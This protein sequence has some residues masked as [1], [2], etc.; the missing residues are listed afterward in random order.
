MPLHKIEWTDKQCGWAV[1]HLTEEETTLAGKAAPDAC[2]ADIISQLK[3]REW[4]AGRILIRKLVE[5][6]GLTYHGLTKDDFGKPFLEGH[7]HHI[8]LSHSHPYV[9][10]Q[11]D[12]TSAVGIDVEQPNEKLLRIGPRVFDPGE[13]KDAGQ[14]IIKNCVYWC[15]KEALFKIYGQKGISFTRN[16]KVQPFILASHG[17]LDGRIILPGY[18]QFVKLAYAIE[19]DIVMVHTKTG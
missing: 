17:E 3:R 8:S 13:V 5:E 19:P 16:L 11:L 14:D 9:A 1:W 10:A 6:A 18:N 7:A 4:L 12:R 2:P 15:A